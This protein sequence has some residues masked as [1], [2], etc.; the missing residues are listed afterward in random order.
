M[1][2]LGSLHPVWNWIE[3]VGALQKTG[4]P[5]VVVTVAGCT[6]STPR[7]TGA[8]MI[9]A[10]DGEFFGTIGGGHLEALALREALEVARGG[11]ARVTRFPLGARTGQCCGGTV[12]L[13][14]EPQNTQ[15][16]L[17]LFGAGHVGQALCR[18]LQGTPYRIH[19]VDDRPEWLT[20]GAL[21]A[22]L[23]RHDGSFDLVWP[24]LP[25]GPKTHVVVMTHR[26]DWDQDIVEKALR[27]REGASPFAYL[28]VIGS[29]GKWAR[30]RQVL[31]AKGLGEAELSRVRC[32]IGVDIG[33]KA[34]QEVAVS[35]AS[36]LIARVYDRPAGLM[37]SFRQAEAHA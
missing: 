18:T 3:R 31:G 19:L 4:R 36:E 12:D 20:H 17:I 2:G 28:G 30:F 37:P 13:L 22:D 8:K 6:G 1:R 26:H 16:P 7:E 5:F 15:T 24:D 10:D 23:T 9:V 11:Q 33:G 32:P 25:W 35:V 27:G 14:M 34:P 21:P 29:R